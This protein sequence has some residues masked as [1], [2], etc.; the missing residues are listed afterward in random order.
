M[1]VALPGRPLDRDRALPAPETYTPRGADMLPPA[2]AELRPDLG[3]HPALRTPVVSRLALTPRRAINLQDAQCKAFL[4][5]NP[6]KPASR[7]QVGKDRH[8]R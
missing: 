8:G 2:C 3:V 4:P 1:P 6:S 7:F 5:C